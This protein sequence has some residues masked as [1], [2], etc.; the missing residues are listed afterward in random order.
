M[1]SS[2]RASLFGLILALSQSISRLEKEIGL[3]LFDRRRS[4]VSLT[5][6]GRDFLKRT[7]VLVLAERGLAHEVSLIRDSATSPI[8]CVFMAVPLAAARVKRAATSLFECTAS[9]ASA[10]TTATT[11]S[12]NG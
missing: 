5:G 2:F 7:S 8:Q 4:G 10:A 3:V 9:T 6:A 1:N 12:A 11:R